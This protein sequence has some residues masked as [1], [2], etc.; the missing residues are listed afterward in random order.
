MKLGGSH[1][2][3]QVTA[4][5]LNIKYSAIGNFTH[6]TASRLGQ[7]S[8]FSPPITSKVIHI[9]SLR[10]YFNPLLGLLTNINSP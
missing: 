6:S 8:H 2:I 1:E 5:Q 10:D 4:E 7:L 9:Q 3:I